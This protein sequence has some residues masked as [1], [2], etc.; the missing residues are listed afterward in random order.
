[1]AMRA[2][3]AARSNAPT[4]LI[5]PLLDDV[6]GARPEL[7]TFSEHLFFRLTDPTR[8][9]RSCANWTRSPAPGQSLQPEVLNKI[10]EWLGAEG[11]SGQ[12]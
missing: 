9:S 1:M 8:P 4:D 12:A 10:Q 5:E 2:K 7:R 6:T 11:G 3:T